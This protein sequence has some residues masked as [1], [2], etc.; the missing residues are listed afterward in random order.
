M[1]NKEKEQERAEGGIVNFANEVEFVGKHSDSVIAEVS[2]QHFIYSLVG[3]G[4][5]LVCVIGAIVLAVL[6]VTGK[7]SWSVKFIGVRSEILD[8]AP[9]AVLF[10]VGLFTLWI[11]RFRVKSKR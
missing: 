7:M 5:M 11:T 2:K 9:A 3:Q 6:E 8:A 10:I 1:S 4:V